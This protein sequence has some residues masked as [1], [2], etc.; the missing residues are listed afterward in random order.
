MIFIFSNHKT[1]DIINAIIVVFI[2][3]LALGKPTWQQHPF[4]TDSFSFSSENAVDGLYSDRLPFANQCTISE[5]FLY[6]A[7]WG[8]DL[9]SVASISH[10]NIFYRTDNLP[11]MNIHMIFKRRRVKFLNLRIFFYQ[12]HENCLNKTRGYIVPQSL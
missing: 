9:G 1:Q 6:T 7:E 8:V 3:N 5:N 11:S 2:E 10:I 12:I 4:R